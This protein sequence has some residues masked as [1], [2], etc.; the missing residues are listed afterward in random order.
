MTAPASPHPEHLL[1][2]ANALRALAR[3][4][5]RGADAAD[6][7]VQSTWVRALEHR[8]RSLQNPFAWLAKV[9]R[10]EA[11]QERRRQA[12]ADAREQ[13]RAVPNEA[14]PV[15][16]VVERIGLQRQLLDAIEALD[17]IYRDVVYLRFFE[18][19]PPRV[20]ASRLAI[21]RRTVDTRL[22]RALAQLRARLDGAHGRDRRA[23][24]G[25]VAALVGAR[26]RWLPL[27]VGAT[28]MQTKFV[29]AGAAV[30]A[31]VTL[32]LGT[33][34]GGDAS[35]AVPS[36]TDAG[37]AVTLGGAGTPGAG[38]ALGVTA[39]LAAGSRTELSPGATPPTAREAGLAGR[40]VDASARAVGGLRVEFV[41]G[42]P[43]QPD[44]AVAAVTAADGR[45]VIA[46][47]AISG[48][49]R[50]ADPGFTTL[51]AAVPAMD[52]ES[53]L[54][55]AAATRFAG[56]VVHA[57]GTPVPGATLTLQLPEGFRTR[58][59]MPLAQSQDEEWRAT[60]DLAGRFR[61]E[62]APLLDGCRLGVAAPEHA[63]AALVVSLAE[64]HR[65]RIVLQ[66]LAP[67]AAELTG[68]VYDGD[69]NPVAGAWVALGRRPERTG[70]DGRFRFRV[71]NAA[72]NQ[73]TAVATGW[74][75]VTVRREELAGEQWPA[76][77]EL[78]LV[79]RPLAIEGQV[80]DAQGRPHP[81][82]RVWAHDV[83]YFARGEGWPLSLEHT[84]AKGEQLWRAVT[85]DADG[86]FAVPGL[87]DRTYELRAVDDRT[88]E[89]VVVRDVRAGGKGV[90]VRMP[91]GGRLE[92]LRGRVLDTAGEPVAG[93]E[94][95]TERDCFTVS[96]MGRGGKGQP[97]DE[98]WVCQ[99]GGPSAMTGE[100]GTFELRDVAREGVVL[101]LGAQDKLIT[102]E[103]RFAGDLVVSPIEIR[104]QLR[105]QIRIDLA[106]SAL[107]A[108]DG[109]E[110]LDA[111][112]ARLRIERHSA[113]E[114][115]LEERTKL[116]D[117][118]SEVLA[119]P[120]VAIEVVLRKGE[121]IVGR[122]PVRPSRREVF[123]VR[124]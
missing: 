24:I 20:I 121:E 26:P 101:R 79:R 56:E 113:G 85:T 63:S 104:V 76:Y 18:G 75:P 88:L 82:A 33:R 103:F 69:G 77:V 70:A 67:P 12:R 61:F 91:V 87:A 22:T 19:L 124:G 7:L 62:A 64:C 73:L 58:L 122:L 78:R 43:P 94:V 107:G 72:E 114:V 71:E 8:P 50:A 1:A 90:E 11:R 57:D 9:L 27:A 92:H 95:R 13:A 37:P 109:A 39:P 49:V 84:M 46:A 4:L 52:G 45:F 106:G 35:P 44:A 111:R 16:R 10:N 29:V 32:Y 54:V 83:T 38:S 21:P 86:R 110:V 17:P 97:E 74:L 28:I 14:P 119:V 99:V 31:A 102:S 34:S 68:V 120:D 105:C 6:D 80:L 42:R 51:L 118:R 36:S 47:S 116:T 30:L 55:V 115:F 98:T 100:D 25:G 53:T 89:Q 123:V 41:P 15:D 117:G 40:A 81:R 65:L 3:Q 5:V 66:P 48:T 96:S 112:G 93:V 108:A 59:A 2:H 23:W 60:A